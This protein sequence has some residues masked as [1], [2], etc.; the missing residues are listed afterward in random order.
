MTES[1]L[2]F[3]QEAVTHAREMKLQHAV[4]F[5]RGLLES[6]DD[7]SIKAVINPIYVMLTESDRQL[8]LIQGGQLKLK[9]PANGNG[10]SGGKS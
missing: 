6:L 8:E 10:Q 1:Q 3:A 4:V 7:P 9:L 2:F 5:L